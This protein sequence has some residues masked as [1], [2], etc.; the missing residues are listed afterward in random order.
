MVAM[1]GGPEGPQ[2]EGGKPHD[3]LL[4]VL[5]WLEAEAEKSIAVIK[6]E[7][8]NLEMHYIHEKKEE[9]GNVVVP[10]GK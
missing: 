7:F 5:P 9:R 6:Q 8:P 1:G 4:C 3:F 10:K 2:R